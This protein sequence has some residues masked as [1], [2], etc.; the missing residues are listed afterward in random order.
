MKLFFSQKKNKKTLV[1]WVLPIF[2]IQ[3][4]LSSG[5][6]NRTYHKIRYSAKEIRQKI[7]KMGKRLQ[8]YTFLRHCCQR[9]YAQH[10]FC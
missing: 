7:S 4:P 8:A 9:F 6:R 3:I 10:I 1:Y 2:A 5:C